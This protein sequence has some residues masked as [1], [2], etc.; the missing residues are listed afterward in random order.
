MIDAGHWFQQIDHSGLAPL[1]NSK[2]IYVFR[3][4]TTELR[5]LTADSTGLTLPS[6][7]FPAGWRFERSVMLRLSKKT[8]KHELA[9]ATLAAIAK[10][11]FYLTHAAI[12]GFP[13]EAE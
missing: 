7:T 6:Q 10:H 3:Y 5:A 4:G 12:Q 1:S 2:E 11:G 13:I 8:P 9:K